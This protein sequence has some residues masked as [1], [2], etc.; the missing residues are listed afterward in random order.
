MQVV[1]T[2]RF[3]GGAQAMIDDQIFDRFGRGAPGAVAIGP[4]RA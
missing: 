4:R 3:K 2:E 1:I